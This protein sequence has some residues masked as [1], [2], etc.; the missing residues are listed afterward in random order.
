MQIINSKNKFIERILRDN[1]GRL[2]CAKFCVYERGGRIKARLVDFTYIDE[3]IF[4]S[5]AV[6]SLPGFKNTKLTWSEFFGNKKTFSP[7]LKSEILYSSGSK[8]RAPSF[9]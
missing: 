3:T 9:A 2:V 5:G 1:E 6:L 7:Q 4:V 8:P